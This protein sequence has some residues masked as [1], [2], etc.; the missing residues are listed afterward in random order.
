MTSPCSGLD[1]DGESVATNIYPGAS[2]VNN[3]RDSAT[4]SQR[5][6]RSKR[7]PKYQLKGLT[8]AS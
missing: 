4:E 5:G 3:E 7:P 2:E 1:E 6:S 8:T